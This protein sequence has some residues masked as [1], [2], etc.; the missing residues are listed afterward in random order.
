NISNEWAIRRFSMNKEA[1]MKCDNCQREIFAL[2]GVYCGSCH[3]KRANQ[4]FQESQ[5]R[6]L[7][8]AVEG[9]NKASQKRLADFTNQELKAELLR[10][11]EEEQLRLLLS[12]ILNTAW[13]AVNGPELPEENEPEKE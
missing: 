9:I 11:A 1:L 6:I 5:E 8:T 13:Q 7:E 2:Y 4:A 10:R 3:R 12:I